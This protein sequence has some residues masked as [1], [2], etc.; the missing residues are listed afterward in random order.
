MLGGLEQLAEA[1]AT[2]A[3]GHPQ[4]NNH[5]THVA[6]QTLLPSSSR[7]GEDDIEDDGEEDEEDYVEDEEYGEDEDDEGKRVSRRNKTIISVKTTTVVS[8]TSEG[9]VEIIE[10]STSSSSLSSSTAISNQ[11][12]INNANTVKGATKTKKKPNEGAVAGGLNV[13]VNMNMNH[14]DAFKIKKRVSHSMIE[15]RRRQTINEKV[16]Q[17]RSLI[18]DCADRTG[19]QMVFILQKA[20]E[21]MEALKAENQ[22]LKEG[23]PQAFPA[24]YG[25]P[26]IYANHPN[27]LRTFFYPNANLSTMPLASSSSLVAPS[28]SMTLS[29]SPLNNMNLNMAFFPVPSTSTSASAST[30]ATNPSGKDL[31]QDVRF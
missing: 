12:G 24:G 14:S 19:L 23:S 1:A 28:I 21:Y 17:L 25:I 20:V 2:E 5:N 29:K 15:K 4:D 6:K 16:A 8:S 3:H 31:A 26:V 11:K 13:N 30:S 27:Q 22:L 10:R 7:N 18:P 9:S